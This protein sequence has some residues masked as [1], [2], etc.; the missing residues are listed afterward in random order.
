MAK[1][2]T[3]PGLIDP[4][5]HLRDPW[6]LQKEDFY[7]GTAAALAGGYVVVMDMPNNEQHITTAALLDKKIASARSKIVCDVGFHFGSLGGNIAEFAKVRGK[8]CGLKLYVTL[9]TNMAERRALSD[10]D[11]LVEIANAWPSD[12][13]LLF[14]AE[15]ATVRLGI[16]TVRRSNHFA[17]FCHIS[18]EQELTPI[19]RAKAEGLPI[20]CG[21]TPHHLFLTKADKQ[22][23]G[24]LS[25]VKPAL[26]SRADQKFLWDYLDGI[27]I[28]ESDHAPH[29]RQEKKT[30]APPGLPGLETTLPL[31]LTAEAEGRLSR[32]QLLDRL[33]H[34]PARIFNVPTDNNTHIEVAM[35]EYE[36]K[37]EDLL[38]KCGWSPFAGRRVIGKVQRVT[39]RGETVFENGRVLAK[40]GSGR[41][42]P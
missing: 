32:A 5:V 36:I 18:S 14:H 26:R 22:R 16:E 31:L 19:L 17:H 23:L 2:I 37:N 41:I 11:E 28:I 27:D 7:T 39:L 40:P 1:T 30:A 42:L 25:S 34:N 13:P 4:H 29:T 38:T 33:H 6:Q 21:V 15:D 20:S 12:K 10:I 8:A 9:T 35:A 24:S 3:L